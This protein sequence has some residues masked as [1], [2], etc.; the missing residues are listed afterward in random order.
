MN[1]ISQSV[2]KRDHAPK[3]EGRSVYVGDYQT[4]RD[5]RPFLTG[6]L[7]YSE[8]ARAKV[9]S[10]TLPP[11]P[12]GYVYADAKDVPGENVVYVVENDLPVFCRNTVEYAG[13][14][15]GMLAGPDAM[16]VERLL[17]QIRVEYEEL[18]AV[19]DPRKATENFI[20]CDFGYADAESAFAEADRVI[21]EEFET[22]YQEHAYLEPQGIIAEPEAGGGLF[23]HGSCQCAWS[24]HLALMRALGR[25]EGSVH[26][27]QDVTGGGFGG[28]ESYP[29]LLACQTAVTAL[30]ANA[31]VRCVLSRKE[32][33]AYSFKRHPSVCRFRMALKAGKITAVDGDI[34]LDGGAYTTLS[35]G[36]L[37]RG[38]SSAAG[39]YVFPNLHLRGRVVKTNT[40]PNDAFRGFGG[41]QVIFAIERMMD[42]AARELGVAPLKLRQQY[43]AKQGDLTPTSGRYHD[44]VPL[45]EMIDEITAQT[46]YWR[47]RAEYAKPQTGRMRRGIGLSL[48]LHGSGMSGTQEKDLFRPCVQLHKDE[49]GRVEILAANGDIGQGVRTTFPKIVAETLDVPLEQV[50]F[51]HPDTARVPDSGPT[52]ASRSI[53]TVG[54][55]LRRAAL[56]LRAEWIDGKEQTVEERYIADPDFVITF[57]F[58]TFQGDAYHVYSW[59]VD[60]VEAEVDTY[61]G[62]V[63]VLDAAGIFDVGTV[64]DKNI[65]IGQMEGGFLQGI[66]W[67]AM[68]KMEADDSGRIRGASFTD[69][70]IPTAKD[71]PNLRV[72]LHSQPYADGPYGAKGAGELPLV[73]A[74]PA[75][76]AA[77]EQA[78]GTDRHFIRKCPCTP[79]EI[80]AELAKEGQSDE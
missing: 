22:A 13:E 51:E 46:D 49:N 25:D 55:L 29:S 77:V 17:G 28:K 47:K 65:V 21:E 34:I 73:G 7:L 19:L 16:E 62:M 8:K 36:V 78:I 80:M 64:I 6:M 15:I 63:R 61:T 11:L 41:P 53:M 66:G 74:A 35:G 68:E 43:L 50:F 27:M 14:A 23:V 33:M 38:V 42:R 48:S 70:L 40:V 20:F 3:T 37:T 54:E 31:P 39:V 57:D 24:V 32:D 52:S 71:V 45:P 44:P 12:E 1:R 9:L 5:G 76:I 4:A 2:V 18:E 67:A 10:V 60:V 69:Y 30:K 72:M 75:Y 59:S 58:D 79:D 26:M 56:K